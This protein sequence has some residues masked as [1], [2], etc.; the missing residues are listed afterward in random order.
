[1][2]YIFIVIVAI[3]WGIADFLR[4]LSSG[5][6]NDQLLSFVFNLGATLSPLVILIFLIYRK[7]PIKYNS[8][9]LMLSLLG[10]V[11]A[12]IGGIL[13]FYLLSRGQS[14]SILFP[15]IRVGS[16]VFVTLCGFIFLSEPITF[17]ILIGLVFSLTGI[18]FIIS[19]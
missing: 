8:N 18:L 6:T 11:L 10:G 13:L 17:K 7:F 19:K 15:L 16:L 5:S 2:N 3:L 4:K 9:H 1:M 12:G 14:I